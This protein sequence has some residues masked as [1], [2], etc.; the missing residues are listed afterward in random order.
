MYLA[1]ASDI[2]WPLWVMPYLSSGREAAAERR[3]P[4]SHATQRRWPRSTPR[5][6]HRID[7][8]A[9]AQGH[10]KRGGERIVLS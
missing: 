7:M 3:E 1:R 9:G 4:E 8:Q 6:V 2:L 10:A 5:V